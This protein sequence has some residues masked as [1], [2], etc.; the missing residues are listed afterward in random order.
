MSS[1]QQTITRTDGY[2]S[3]LSFDH[4]GTVIETEHACTFSFS[5][6]FGQRLNLTLLDFTPRNHTTINIGLGLGELTG[7]LHHGGAAEPMQDNDH[8][9]GESPGG[10]GGGGVFK[11]CRRLAVVTETH[12]GETMSVCVGVDRES[13]VYIS[14]TNHVHMQILPVAQ[15][16]RYLIKFEGRLWF[17][18]KLG[19]L[20]SAQQLLEAG[21][22]STH[23]LQVV[24]NVKIELNG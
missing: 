7:A 22:Q 1:G 20:K 2:I 24:G 11:P 12:L 23:A 14:R 16:S 5:V 4:R 21:K 17:N 15:I 10:V 13:H 3:G 18:L 9:L 19:N 6:H 8:S